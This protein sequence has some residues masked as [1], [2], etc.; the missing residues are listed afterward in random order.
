MCKQIFLIVVFCCKQGISHF[1]EMSCLCRVVEFELACYARFGVSGTES[2]VACYARFGVSGTESR[3]NYTPMTELDYGTLLCWANNSIGTQDHPCVFQIVA[4]GQ[5]QLFKTFR[6]SSRQSL[7]VSLSP[8]RPSVRR[9]PDSRCR[10]FSALQDLPCVFQIIDAAQS[11]PSIIIHASS[12]KSLPVN[13][14]SQP[15]GPSIVLH[16]WSNLQLT[17]HQ[18]RNLGVM[19]TKDFKLQKQSENGCKT[20]C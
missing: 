8:S 9:L 13:L 5:S 11:L 1:V 10:L 15:P 6:A 20:T 17:I 16:G 12:R 3:V 18:H 14:N 2:R 7:Q 4:A 19:I